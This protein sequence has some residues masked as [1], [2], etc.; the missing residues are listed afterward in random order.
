MYIMW[1]E[2]T[3]CKGIYTQFHLCKVQ[4]QAKLTSGA[5][6]Q[7]GSEEERIICWAESERKW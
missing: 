7:D 3:R 5:K 4:T 2:T 1:S 6:S